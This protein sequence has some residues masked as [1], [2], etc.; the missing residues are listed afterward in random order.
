VPD[1]HELDRR[2]REGLAEI[3]RLLTGYSEYVPN[4]FSLKALDEHI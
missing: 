1:G 3:K 2:L 4:T